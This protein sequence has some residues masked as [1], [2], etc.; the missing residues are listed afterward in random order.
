MTSFNCLC[1]SREG[2]GIANWTLLLSPSSSHDMPWLPTDG[3]IKSKSLRLIFKS[4]LV[5]TPLTSVTQS[6]ITITNKNSCSSQLGLLTVTQTGQRHF[7]SS[8]C[9]GLSASSVSR[10]L[11]VHSADDLACYLIGDVKPTAVFNTI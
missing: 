6:C 5:W 11:S 1:C 3:K 4:P 8:A 10:A 2:I 7:C 9:P